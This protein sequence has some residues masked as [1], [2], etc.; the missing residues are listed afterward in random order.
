MD[1]DIELVKDLKTISAFIKDKEP[2]I[3]KEQTII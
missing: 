1:A 2:L 3:A